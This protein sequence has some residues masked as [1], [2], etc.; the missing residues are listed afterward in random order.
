MDRV[1]SG[2]GIKAE[3][4][5][6]VLKGIIYGSPPLG[7]QNFSRVGSGI[8]HNSFEF[9]IYIIVFVHCTLA[10]PNETKGQ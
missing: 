3:A 10:N 8:H 6:R 7:S 1:F 2:K 9:L 4:K 5:P